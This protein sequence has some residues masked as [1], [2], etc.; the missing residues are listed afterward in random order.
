LPAI[1]IHFF[2]DTA[3]QAPVR[4][5]LAR[6]RVQDSKAYAK[7]VAR[8]RR[9]A[10]EGHELRRPEADYLGDGIYELRIRKAR[11]NY[12][13]LYFFHGP[14][15]ALLAHAITKE[16]AIPVVEL[17]RVVERKRLYEADPNRHT[18]QEDVVDG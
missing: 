14:R 5:W 10:S 9:L 11:V 6:L 12:R 18:Y 3:G 4:E 8:I 2:Q 17:A 15:L 1:S 7:C 13:V 16:A